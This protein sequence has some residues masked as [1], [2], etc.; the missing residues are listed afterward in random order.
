ML[1]ELQ[2]RLS[3]A[4]NEQ[5][6]KIYSHGILGLNDEKTETVELAF[7]ITCSAEKMLEDS[8]DKAWKSAQKFESPDKATLDYIRDIYKI[9][10]EVMDRDHPDH[11]PDA[12]TFTQR[13]DI[14][15]RV[16]G[17]TKFSKFLWKLKDLRNDL[18]H[19]RIMNLRYEGGNLHERSIREVFIYDFIDCLA[20]NNWEDSNLWDDLTDE[21]KAKLKK[22]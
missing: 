12:I 22:L 20:N 10:I 1:K 14:F 21:Q 11:D 2:D 17:K 4:S 5:M 18:S 15:Q 9:R 8:L 7:W 6:K 3:T 13:I 19:G 16:I